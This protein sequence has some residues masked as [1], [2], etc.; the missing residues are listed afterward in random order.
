MRSLC[1]PSRM[2]FCLHVLLH[3]R[4]AQH[5]TS[6]RRFTLDAAAARRCPNTVHM[7]QTPHLNYLLH[8]GFLDI[9]CFLP[10]T[11]MIHFHNDDEAAE[12]SHTNNNGYYANLHGHHT[13][14]AFDRLLLTGV[15]TPTYGKRRA[16]W[17]AHNVRYDSQTAHHGEAAVHRVKQFYRSRQSMIRMPFSQGHILCKAVATLHSTGTIVLVL[18]VHAAQAL[19]QFVKHDIHQ[20]TKNHTGD[21]TA[22]SGESCCLHLYCYLAR[23]CAASAPAWLRVCFMCQQPFQFRGRMV[24]ALGS[25]RLPHAWDTTTH[26]STPALEQVQHQLIIQSCAF[27]CAEGLCQIA[28]LG[29]HASC[30]LP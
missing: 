1:G 12:G 13:A 8:V 16:D 11:N 15:D 17:P 6:S 19:L 24:L 23:R 25:L 26:A 7:P 28:V 9:C 29:G 4:C 27:Q 10:H 5:W 21:S 3:A 18:L 20:G 2:P 30:S 22:L 14:L